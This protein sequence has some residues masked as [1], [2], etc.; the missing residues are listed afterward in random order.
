LL[1]RLGLGLALREEDHECCRQGQ[2][3]GESTGQPEGPGHLKAHTIPFASFIK[4][5]GSRG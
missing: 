3:Q 4:R 5:Q 1:L 2:S